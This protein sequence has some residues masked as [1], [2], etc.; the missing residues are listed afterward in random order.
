VTQTGDWWLSPPP[1]PLHD[2]AIRVLGD[3]WGTEPLLVREGGSM[4][5]MRVMERAFEAQALV[6]PM[7]MHSDAAHLPNERIRLKNLVNGKEV[8]KRIFAG[9]GALG[10]K[11]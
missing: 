10:F 11:K 2:L 8:L 7:G 1:T 4:P 9:L 6:I 3:V 5:V